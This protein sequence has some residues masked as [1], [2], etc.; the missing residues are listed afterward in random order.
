MKRY[1]TIINLLLT[2]AVIYLCVDTFD[3]IAATRAD[4]NPAV[5]RRQKQKVNTGAEI[6]P[7][8]ESYRAITD[9]NLFDTKTE[10]A[11]PP[12]QMAIEKL[13]KTT[14]KLKLWG[15]VTGEGGK[16]YAVIE[17]PAKREQNLYRIGDTIQ[18]AA[19]KIILREKVVLHVSGK[20]EILSMEEVKSTGTSRP[21]A[22]RRRAARPS[23]TQKIVLKQSQLIGALQDPGALMKQ[24]RVRPHFKDGKPDGLLVTGIKPASIFRKMGLRNGDI[25]VGVDEADI[26]SIDDAMK[27]YQGLGASSE[28]KLQIKRR[29]RMRTLEYAIQ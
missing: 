5:D 4:T 12:K 7:L 20:D 8:P 1:L 17:D 29:G 25:L 16:A 14:L 15:T 28:V 27:F 6:P 10:A 19:V 21:A 26:S 24:A 11:A 9:R 23:P 2:T 18:N 22:A 13:Q 3:K